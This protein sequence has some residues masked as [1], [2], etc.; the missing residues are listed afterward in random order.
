MTEMKFSVP[1]M[2]CGHCEKR[3][4]GVLTGRLGCQD[5]VIDLVHKT[6]SLRGERTFDEVRSALEEI[7]YTAMA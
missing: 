7:G 1:D 2:N 5:V 4:R 3:I 6:V